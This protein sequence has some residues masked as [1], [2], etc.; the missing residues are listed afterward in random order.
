MH[1]FFDGDIGCG[2]IAN[3]GDR[4]G[5]PRIEERSP[6][7][8]APLRLQQD[9]PKCLGTKKVFS[10]WKTRLRLCGDGSYWK[11]VI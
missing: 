4:Q 9:L 8:H 5:E 10:S 3:T 6:S 7:F 1:R 2:G 11:A